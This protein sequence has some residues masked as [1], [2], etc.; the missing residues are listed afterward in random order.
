L[1][2]LN[3]LECVEGQVWAN[4]SPTDLIA[5]IDPST[6]KV[7]AVVNGARLLDD[8]RRAQGQGEI[9]NGIAYAGAGEFLLTGKYWPAMF[10]VRFDGLL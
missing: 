2:G 7:T 4:V 3:E 6:G 8:A 10:R 1:T 9:L 5:R